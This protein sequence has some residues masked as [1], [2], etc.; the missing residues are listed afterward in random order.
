MERA[1]VHFITRAKANLQNL[2]TYQPIPY[3]DMSTR[4]DEEPITFREESPRMQLERSRYRRGTIA[5]LIS[6]RHAAQRATVA[7]DYE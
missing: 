6:K 4:D 1:G 3:L 5:E 2:L 7:S